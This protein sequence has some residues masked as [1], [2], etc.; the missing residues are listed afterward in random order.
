MKETKI[1]TQ[2]FNSRLQLREAFIEKEN[3]LT[4]ATQDNKIW[5]DA[6]ADDMLDGIER[7]PFDE[8]AQTIDYCFEKA[9][10]DLKSKVFTKYHSDLI[11]KLS[12]NYD[13]WDLVQRIQDGI[14]PEKDWPNYNRYLEAVAKAKTKF[15]ASPEAT[16]LR[17]LQEEWRN[18]SKTPR[19]SFSDI[20]WSVSENRNQFCEWL[21]SCSDEEDAKWLLSEMNYSACFDYEDFFYGIPFWITHDDNGFLVRKG[22]LLDMSFLL[23]WA[24]DEFGSCA[25]LESAISSNLSETI[26]NYPEE[27]L[28]IIE[29]DGYSFSKEIVKALEEK[30]PEIPDELQ[31][32]YKQLFDEIKEFC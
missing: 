17:Q 14:L 23:E 3:E 1:N 9:Y 4:S 7:T 20:D 27:M 19:G 32:D 10:H 11:S 18:L 12:E 6:N 15:D 24:G 8:I 22:L 28:N 31:N 5:L 16:E 29:N 2:D 25:I 30:W 21:N 13:N 26:S